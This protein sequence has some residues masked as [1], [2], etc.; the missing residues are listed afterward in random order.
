MQENAMRV[1]PLPVGI[2]IL[3]LSTSLAFASGTQRSPYAFGEVA[4]WD[5][6]DHILTL[7]TGA[8]YYLP[9]IYN[10]P[11]AFAW[12]DQVRIIYTAFGDTNYAS[13]VTVI[14]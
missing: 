2:G 5:A 14:G 13:W 4:S 9:P 7:V 11:T 1:F 10:S 6:K 3:A 12:G 8:E